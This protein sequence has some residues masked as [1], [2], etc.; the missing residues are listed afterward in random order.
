MTVV[1][2]S[3]FENT[4]VNEL[5]TLFLPVSSP[6]RC[7]GSAVCQFFFA[8]FTNLRLRVQSRQLNLGELDVTPIRLATTMTAFRLRGA[9]SRQQGTTVKLYRTPLQ[10]KWGTNVLTGKE[11]YK[12]HV[13]SSQC[14]ATIKSSEYPIPR[15]REP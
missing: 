4:N 12:C 10:L 15:P 1:V 7:C 3:C 5:S 2:H 11:E 8:S 9:E 14:T 6:P 13:Q